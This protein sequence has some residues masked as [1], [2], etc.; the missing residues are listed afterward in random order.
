MMNILA[1][2]LS[3]TYVTW[4]LL[5]DHHGPFPMKYNVV[6]Q[7]GYGSRRANLFDSFRR[8]FGVYEL[9]TIAWKDAE[10]Q[11]EVIQWVVKPEVFLWYCPF[12]LSFWMQI[13]FLCAYVYLEFITAEIAIQLIFVLPLIVGVSAKLLDILVTT[14]RVLENLGDALDE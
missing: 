11:K 7:E 8:F 12:C 4:I 10:G 5:L 2:I 1:L 14:N 9:K 3:V 13:P 6:V